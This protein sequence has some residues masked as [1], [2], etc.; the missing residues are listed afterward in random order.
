MRYAPWALFFC[1]GFFLSCPPILGA[2]EKIRTVEVDTNQ[3]GTTDQIRTH[4][5][6]GTIL[7][8]LTDADQDGFFEQKQLYEN[9]E[10]SQLARDTDQDKAYDTFDFMARGKRIRQ[11]K[12]NTRGQIILLTR[13]D[14]SQA[15]IV[16]EKDNTGDGLRDTHYFFT[17]GQVSQSQKDSD[18]NGRP[19]VFIW[20][21][22]GHPV[23]RQVD[24]N[25]DGHME[26][27]IFFDEKGGVKKVLLTPVKGPRE[28]QL[29]SRGQIQETRISTLGD[30]R[31][32]RITLFKKG[33]PHSQKQDRNR[34]GKFDYFAQFDASGNLEIV[35]ED[36]RHRGIIDRIRHFKKGNPTRL[37]WDREGNG[38][39]ETQERYDIPP[40]SRVIRVDANQDQKPEVIHYYTKDGLAKKEVDTTK[41]GV[42][43]RIET[44]G[45]NQRLL[46][47]LERR[48][49]GGDITWFYSKGEM[50]HRAEED[51]NQNGKTD[52]WYW[53]AEDGSLSRIE[54]DTN[55]DGKPDLWEKY[56]KAQALILRQR[57]LDFDGNIDFTDNPSPE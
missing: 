14:E 17:K 12:K 6:A 2:A 22:D 52:I 8:L 36:S 18:A 49:E 26:K 53:Y 47:L 3:D 21:K 15:P 41:D 5:A 10:I 38:F 13:F 56:D 24:A 42:A 37:E 30:D 51:K 1:L 35:K 50:P 31:I 28:T 54:E 33:Q 27:T 16:M 44:Y 11:E 7:S 9:G 46:T 40:W 29:F 19:N 43:D 4:D 20:F 48:G 57:D 25:Q 32:D 39:F 55:Q 45:K 23:K 34:D